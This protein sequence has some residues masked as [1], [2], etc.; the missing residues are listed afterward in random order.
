MLIS[1]TLPVEMSATL[2]VLISTTLPVEISRKL[3]VLI[4]RT[5]PVEMSAAL[6]VLISRTL[7]VEISRRLPVL[8]SRTLPVEISLTLPV[9]MSPI[10][11]CGTTAI[12]HAAPKA[13][14]ALALTI[15]RI[16]SLL[17]CNY[18]N[19]LN[20]EFVYPDLWDLRGILCDTLRAIFGNLA[21]IRG[22]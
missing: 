21:P 9:L 7:P 22:N 5:L 14:T 13:S 20:P 8:I 18:S 10:A 16:F 4:S 1:R 2:P 12:T 15:A 17:I 11:P 3:P 19:P 6:P